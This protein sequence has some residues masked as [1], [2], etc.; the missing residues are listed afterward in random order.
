MLTS[1]LLRGGSWSPAS[2]LFLAIAVGQAIVNVSLE[3]YFISRLRGHQPSLPYQSSLYIVYDSGFIA[4]QAFALALSYAALHIRSEPLVTAA[5][6]FDLLL[7]LFQAA[8]LAQAGSSLGVVGLQV[9]SMVVL[10]ELLW[11][12]YGSVGVLAV[13]PAFFIY[14]LVV[15]N[16]PVAA[17]TEDVYAAVRTYV[18]FFLVILLVLDIALTAVSLVVART[19]GKGLRQRLRHFQIL[20][21][22]EVDLETMSRA[23]PSAQLSDASDTTGEEL[24]RRVFSVRGFSV[25][26]TSAKNS[27]K[28]SSL[29]FRALFLGLDFPSDRETVRSMHRASVEKWEQAAPGFANPQL[30][31][32]FGSPASTTDR[33]PSQGFGTISSLPEPAQCRS[34]QQMHKAQ[35]SPIASSSSMQFGSRSTAHG[36]FVLSADELDAING[37]GV[38]VLPGSS[39]YSAP[40]FSRSVVIP[41]SLS[42]GRRVGSSGSLYRGPL[43]RENEILSQAGDYATD[44]ALFNTL[45]GP[46]GLHIVNPDGAS[47]GGFIEDLGVSHASLNN[48]QMTDQTAVTAKTLANTSAVFAEASLSDIL[49]EVFDSPR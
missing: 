1:P 21:R 10:A 31:E 34:P 9:V 49:E 43:G 7:L 6:V 23:G 3:S 4:A 2:Q 44:C 32:V 28:E 45:Q 30:L 47:E 36:T 14:K 40:T 17:G 33:S 24:L 5:T 26:V 20:A 38:S 13:A 8:Q 12:M 25:L 18:T 48:G 16:R 37:S 39:L 27:L 11:L 15:V 42:V 35:H 46:L 29:H 22:G 19:F 41:A